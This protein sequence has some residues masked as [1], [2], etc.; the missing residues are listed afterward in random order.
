MRHCRQHH[1]RRGTSLRSR[2]R[3][4]ALQLPVSGLPLVLGAVVAGCAAEPEERAFIE[5]LGS[6]TMA[7][8]VVRRTVD[9]FEGDMLARNPVTLVGHYAVRFGDDGSIAH[10]ELRWETPPGNPDGPA[11]SNVT[12]DVAG[13]S[14]T[15]VR[16]SDSD[17]VTQ[18][19]VASPNPVPTNGR[20]PLAV[21]LFEHAVQLALAD[22]SSGD[23]PFA[24]TMLWP[25]RGRSSPN[26]IT[27]RGPGEL[28][29]D[30]FGNPLIARVDDSGRIT[31]ITG[32]E[33]TVKV[34]I[35]PIEPP[36]LMT[37]AADFAARDAR[38]EG[39]G[40][41]SPGATV[42]ASSGGASFEIT[43]SRPAKR[44]R[45]IWGGLVPYDE[46]WR[47]GANA[48]TQ[49]STDRDL[50]IGDAEVPAG[51]YTLWSIYTPESATLIINSQTGQWGTAYDETQ[52]FVRVPMSRETLDEPTE[53]F[54]ISVEPTG[55]GGILRLSWDRTRYSVSMRVR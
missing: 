30:F 54:T 47:T 13:D 31:S 9:G 19:V 5:R 55:E 28:S 44:G 2:L 46:V 34:E 25:M 32:S 52:D 15:I 10:F 42:T 8:E 27:R 43:Y 40:T 21:G 26:A 41:P 17:T 38:G 14:A 20:V 22:A 23:E 7:I 24:F 48:A 36:D 1:P 39:I 33:T 18:Q 11:P 4:P 29:L 35:E 6:D 53:R 51:D 37:L 3:L 12:I 50:L 45:E 49:F 16:Q